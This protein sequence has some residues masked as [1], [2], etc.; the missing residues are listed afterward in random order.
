MNQ[1]VSILPPA[2]VDPAEPCIVRDVLDR[3]GDRWSLLVLGHLA[4]ES[5]RFNA[6]HRRIGGV[7]KQVLSRT[8][9]R[10]EEDGFVRRIV[11]PST[12][13]SVEY[14][15]SE[16]GESFLPALLGLLNWAKTHYADVQASRDRFRSEDRVV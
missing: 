13:P 6:L 1:R 11:H 16:L 2:D 12:P 9:R 10:L 8:L 4:A 15:L 7:S 14:E 3:V 5:V